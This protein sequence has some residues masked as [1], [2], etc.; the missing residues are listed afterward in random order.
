MSVIVATF[1]WGGGPI[2]IP[3]LALSVMILIFSRSTRVKD[4]EI[5]RIVEKMFSENCKD[6]DDK[7]MISAFYLS[8]ESA[9]KGMDGKTRSPQYVVSYYENVSNGTNI[10]VYCFNLVENTVRKES[11]F[12]NANVKLFLEEHTVILSSGRKKV[13]FLSSN[14][15]GFNIPVTVDDVGSARILEKLC[16]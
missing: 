4:S 14:E 3:L 16:N 13:H 2:G 9:V 8:K 12:V 6:L 15:Q 5:D 10:T 1:V 11:Y 7:N